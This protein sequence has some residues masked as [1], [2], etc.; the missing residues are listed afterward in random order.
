MKTISLS[1]FTTNIQATDALAIGLYGQQGSGK[2]RFCCT[3]PDPIGFIALDRKA[4]KTVMKTASEL[5][6]TVVMPT[7]DFIRVANPQA[8]ASM[9]I[10]AAMKH[11]RAHVDQ[12]K[13]AAFKLYSHKD[14]RTIVIDTGSQLWE[15][16]MF[17]NYGRNQRV[18]PRD[19]GPVN[20]EMI[21]L[22]N[23]LSGKNLIITHKADE[24]WTG[25]GDKAKPSG[26]FKHAG[27]RHIEYHINV[28]AE[29]VCDERKSRDDEGRFYMNVKMCQDNPDIQG[30]NGTKLLIDEEISFPMLAMKI[31]GDENGNGDQ[32]M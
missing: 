3:A 28:M 1:G 8:L 9:Q 21:D 29:M 4:R 13:L 27:F 20:Q 15:D 12:I 17:A 32:W 2:T 22:L 23:A 30:P 16:M 10:D 14:I 18:M 19:R 25:D 7:D 26:K 5:G 11:Y 24:I 31:Y 6:K